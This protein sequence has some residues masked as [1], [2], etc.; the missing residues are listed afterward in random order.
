MALG[1]LDALP[2]EVGRG[3][4]AGQLRARH[5]QRT[6]CA[7]S[8]ADCVAAQTARS[9]GGRLAT[10]DPHLLNFCH[11]ERVE[12]VVPGTDGSTWSPS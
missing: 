7:V 2:V 1:L 9:L 5:Y 11:A 10:S 3:I 8:L 4:G 12:V 6:C